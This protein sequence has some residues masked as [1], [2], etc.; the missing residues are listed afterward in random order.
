MKKLSVIVPV[1]NTSAYLEKC[2]HSITAQTYSELEIILVD[3]GST[4]RAGTICDQ[5]ASE[6]ARISVIHKKN[7]GL[8]S[9]RNIGLDIARGDYITFV[10]S[11]D[12]LSKDMYEALFSVS[13][14]Y[15]QDEH[16]VLCGGFVRVDE[17]GEY[18]PSGVGVDVPIV[19]DG[20]AYIRSLLMHT[21]DV[22]VCT[23]IF[24]A[25]LL[26]GRCFE[27]GRL[28]EDLLFMIELM[29]S[30]S[31]M[32][33]T[34]NRGYH[35]LCRTSSTSGDYGRAV[36]DMVGNAEKICSFVNE[37]YPGLMGERWRFLLVQRS[38]YLLLLPV[39][40]QKREN[41]LYVDT[42]RKLRCEFW[43]HGWNNPYIS[44]KNKL[45]I[46]VQLFS[47]KLMAG[48]RKRKTNY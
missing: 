26:K 3:D 14:A 43:K 7:G 2:V 42:L 31:Y 36:E 16:A 33:F 46:V 21:G 8:S 20:K 29:P 24:P 11:D 4:D 28:N 17:N 40:L 1:Y 48:F 41:L 10:D 34:G 47:P 38:A 9:A 18:L 22:S 37:Q 27:E 19:M 39:G 23:K 45:I 30:V 5:L 44:W 13:E 35:Y 15:L 6:D 12:Y 32:V 25:K